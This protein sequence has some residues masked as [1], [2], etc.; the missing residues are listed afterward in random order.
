MVSCAAEVQA[1]PFQPGGRL[2]LRIRVT[3]AR[4]KAPGREV[5]TVFK[6]LKV[7]TVFI[8]IKANTLQ[9]RKGRIKPR[10][11]VSPGTPWLTTATWRLALRRWVTSRDRRQ[12]GATRS[13]RRRF[14]RGSRGRSRAGRAR[15]RF[16]KSRRRRTR[17]VTIPPG[18]RLIRAAGLVG[19]AR[20]I[21]A[22]TRRLLR[23]TAGTNFSEPPVPAPTRTRR[24]RPCTKPTP[25]E[26]A[27]F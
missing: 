16:R 8:C 3:R 10:P 7:F 24:R 18:T 14:R 12:R 6:M 26:T 5:F 2:G 22:E 1:R 17:W 13:P 25:S 20:L 11:H 23:S 9:T 19:A 4:N 27:P 15:L 21:Q